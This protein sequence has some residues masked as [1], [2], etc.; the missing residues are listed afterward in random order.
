MS[1]RAA[2]VL[3]S[4]ATV[5]VPVAA[6]AEEPARIL[7]YG[8]SNSWGYV[9]RDDGGPTTRYSSAERWTGILQAK[10]GDNAVVLEDGLNLRTTD[11][12]GEDW[13]GSV[14]RPETFNGAR[15]LPAAIAAQMPLDWVVIMLGTNDLQARY[16]RSATEV[17]QAAVRLAQL[18]QNSAGGIGTSYP[19]PRVLL[20]APVQMA[21]LPDAEM[22]LR[23]QGGSEKSA[24]LAAAFAQ[25]AAVADIPLVDA[26]A[27][28]GGAAHGADGLHLSD[29]DHRLLGEAMADRITALLK[30]EAPQ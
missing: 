14:I 18:V 8:D 9:P 27:V 25:A 19:A 26:G 10:L 22:A 6:L 21:T 16:D 20:V 2:A 5:A 30:M 3:L 13:L 4:I 29:A 7:I 28:I 11:L 24:G 1:F 15:H 23:Y 17:A 12:D